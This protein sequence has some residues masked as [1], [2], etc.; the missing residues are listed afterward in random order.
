MKMRFLL[1]LLLLSTSK[2]FS[3]QDTSIVYFPFDQ[4]NLTKEAR[5]ML[6]DFFSKMQ[7]KKPM[8]TIRGHCDAK[9]SDSYNDAL[10]EKRVNSVK[11]Y[12]LEKGMDA[13]LIA[14]SRGYG[15]KQPLNTNR[16]DEERRLNRRVELIWPATETSS[17]ATAENPAKEVTLTQKIDTVKEGEHLRLQNINFYGG[18]H[19]FL[20]Q[21]MPA[22]DELL[23][24]MRS[25]P[26]LVIEIQGHI[27]C[28]L[29]TEDG[30]DYDASDRRLS[31]NRAAAVYNFLVNN[32]IEKERMSF[33]GFAGT[34]R[35]VE[36][37]M[38]E[39]DR[40]LNRRVEIKIVKK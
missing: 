19:T 25:H 18:R 11:Q 3:Q 7:D 23:E 13:S 36:Q 8:L 30:M 10:S 39:A 15:E 9:G 20:P 1:C 40:T 12:L 24:V 16:T 21:S 33:I 27:C 34:Q 5:V 26:T 14:L 37:E 29:G 31:L 35:L 32:G 6:D 28:F 38:T 2:L 17:N 4:S 22:L